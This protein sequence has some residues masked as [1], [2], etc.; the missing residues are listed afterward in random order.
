MLSDDQL[1][2][3]LY[4]DLSKFVMPE[5]VRGRPAWYCQL[6]WLIESLVVAPSPQIAFSWRAWWCRLFGAQLGKGVRIRPG[7]RI[8]YPW[9]L[10][11]GDNVWIGNDVRIYNLAPIA[12]GSHAVVSQGCHLCAGDHDAEDVSFTLRTAPIS[13]GAQAWIAADCFIAPG[14]TIGCGAVVGA[15]S[16]VFSDMPPAMICHGHPCR[17]RRPRLRQSDG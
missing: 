15:R 17:P 11:V 14:V 5:G 4:Q 13:I 3:P 12:I 10:R 6:W 8:V 7:V 9:Q 16:V 2:Q 1:N